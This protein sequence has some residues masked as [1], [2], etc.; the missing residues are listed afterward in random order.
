MFIGELIFNTELQKGDIYRVLED[1]R[2]EG[3]II[4]NTNKWNC[5]A[6]YKGI[7]VKQAVKLEPV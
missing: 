7:G 6:I 5:Y 4:K 3:Y 1:V 2:R